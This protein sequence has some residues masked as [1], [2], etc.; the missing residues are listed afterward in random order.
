MRSFQRDHGL[1]ATGRCDEPTWLALVDSSWRLGDRS[2]RLNVPHSRGEDVVALQTLLARLGFDAGRV[3]G[4][5]GPDTDRALTDFQRNCG[6]KPDG[7]CGPLTVRAIEVNAGRT[8][9]GPGVAALRD[10]VR[11]EAFSSS[12]QG[13][14]V[15]LGHF[16]GLGAV[17]RHLGQVLRQ[18][19][20]RVL[21]ADQLDPSGQAAA[22]NN[23]GADVYV[24]FES[25]LDPEV[26][27]HYWATPAGYSSA[28]GRALAERLVDHLDRAGFGA[29]RAIG[30]RFPVLRETKM[31]AVVCRLGP[32]RAV[33]DRTDLIGTAVTDAL[34]DWA[35]C[36]RP[37]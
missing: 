34:T 33:V 31:S 19:E 21:V 14:R 11:L 4:I 24:G 23:D 27:I 29:G 30:A 37:T 17:T 8:G 25:S 28:G 13:L 7:I 5:F 10:L 2:L 35:R 32:L 26:D 18:H 3:D 9:T 22:A 36:P 1:P 12:L 6:L 16:G 20:A 15:V